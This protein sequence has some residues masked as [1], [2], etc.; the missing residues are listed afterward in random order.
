MHVRP[1]MFDADHDPIQGR[2]SRA[3][4]ALLALPLTT[5]TEANTRSA[6]SVRVTGTDRDVL[7]LWGANARWSG[8][9]ELPLEELIERGTE[10][11]SKSR[12]DGP[13]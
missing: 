1:E 3:S 8:R 11:L 9:L 7:R 5:E 12:A 2:D 6:W 10:K 4:R 13:R